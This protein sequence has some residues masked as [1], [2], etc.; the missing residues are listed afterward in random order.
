VKRLHRTG[1]PPPGS[2]GDLRLVMGGAL[3]FTESQCHGRLR[4]RGLG[5]KRCQWRPVA[6]AR[7]PCD[8]EHGCD[9][10]GD[11]CGDGKRHQAAPRPPPSNGSAAVTC[12]AHRVPLH[13]TRVGSQAAHTGQV[14]SVSSGRLR[15][16]DAAPDQR[17]ALARNV[18]RV[19]QRYDD[20]GLPRIPS[21]H[22]KFNAQTSAHAMPGMN[23]SWLGHRDRIHEPPTTSASI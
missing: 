21:C 5:G 4:R 7:Q 19:R 16:M 1:R 17:T 18:K 13:P 22:V 6:R 14:V 11:T 8:G 2:D 9:D 15:L 3:R 20:S 10:D 23:I 12:P